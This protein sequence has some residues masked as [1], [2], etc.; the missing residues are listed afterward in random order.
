MLIAASSSARIS[1][2]R[3]RAASASRWRLRSRRQAADHTWCRPRSS[4]T[5]Q[6]GHR[7]ASTGVRTRSEPL[8]DVVSTEDMSGPTGG[9][10]RAGIEAE[11]PG[12]PSQ[13]G[14][15]DGLIGLRRPAHETAPGRRRDVRRQPEARPQEVRRRPGMDAGE[16]EAEGTAREDLVRASFLS[17]AAAYRAWLRRVER[18]DRQATAWLERWEER[19]GPNLRGE[20]D[21]FRRLR[22][23][24]RQ[25][26]A[27][28]SC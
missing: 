22:R 23:L 27:R 5:P 4:I 9:P 17:G 19:W 2:L 15:H 12:E 10:G 14:R 7:E 11:R 25:T 20:R 21:A 3:L 26:G 18:V 24:T 16:E 6:T 28:L 8:G 1:A 13:P